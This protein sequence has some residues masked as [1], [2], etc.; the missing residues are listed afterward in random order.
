MWESAGECGEMWESVRRCARVCEGVR[1]RGGVRASAGVRVYW[2]GR[3]IHTSMLSRATPS[4]SSERLVA[5]R[6]E[7]AEAAAAA[8]GLILPQSECGRAGPDCAMGGAVAWLD[9][10]A[11]LDAVAGVSRRTRA[12]E[13]STPPMESS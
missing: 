8:G 4:T 9:A 13:A 6:A 1:G 12:K 3:A 5:T 2:I 7:A 10:V 11:R